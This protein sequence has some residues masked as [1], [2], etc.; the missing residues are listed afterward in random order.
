MSSRLMS[1]SSPWSAGAAAVAVVASS[2]S[3]AGCGDQAAEAQSHA[4]WALTQIHPVVARDVG[5][6]R[7]GLPK[8]AAALA[9]DLGD[10]PAADPAGLQRRIKAARERTNELNVAKSTFFSFATVDGVV[11]RSEADP[12][13]L[14]E[15]NVLG[16]FPTLKKAL[17]PGAAVVEATGEMDEMRGVR[18]GQDTTF[19]AAHAVPGKEGG[20]ARGLFVTGWSYRAYAFYLEEAARRALAE[21]ARKQEKN[22]TP[23]AYV[24]LARGGKAYGAPVSP[25]VNAEA[26]AKA[27]L[28]AKC[29]DGPWQGRIDIADRPFGAAAQRLPELGEDATLVVLATVF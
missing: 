4:V 19:V 3:L 21:E 16:P 23:V 25:D 13:R 22:K 27:D 8:G 12:D 28:A 17:E 7:E 9:K 24:Y 18:T 29:K 6:I 14:V 2:L 15:K 5:Q 26:V 10:D 20:P 11:L 1:F